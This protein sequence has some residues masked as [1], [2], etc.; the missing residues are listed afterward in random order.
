MKGGKNKRE[1]K[2][3]NIPYIIKKYGKVKIKVGKVKDF[4]K[5]FYYN[6]ASLKKG[7]NKP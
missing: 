7:G 1:K 6:N 5:I 4:F 2:K 3:N